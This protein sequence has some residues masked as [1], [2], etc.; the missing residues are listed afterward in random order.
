MREECVCANTSVKSNALW[1]SEICASCWVLFKCE[2]PAPWGCQS[3]WDHLGQVLPRN[4]MPG[5]WR[6]SVE[7][8][9]KYSLKCRHT[10]LYW[11][12]LYC[13]LQIL[14]FSQI[15]GVSSKSLA[16]IL[17][18]AFARFMSLYHI[19]VILRNSHFFIIIIFVR[20]SVIRDL[21]CYYHN[22]L[23][24]YFSHQVF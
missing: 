9:R 5:R 14:H 1:T 8:T 13:T 12:L 16:A 7:N 6:W 18:A 2:L 24:I 23:G 19:L 11:N 3:S 10:S 4:K 22:G 15:Q 20:G 21:W 17:P